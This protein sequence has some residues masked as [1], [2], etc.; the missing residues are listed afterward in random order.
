MTNSLNAIFA[1]MNDYQTN[2]IN[3][4]IGFSSAIADSVSN[5]LHC[6]RRRSISCLSICCASKSNVIQ[7]DGSVQTGQSV[8]INIHRNMRRKVIREWQPST[9]T[10]SEVGTTPSAIMS[11]CTFRTLQLLATSDFGGFLESVN[12]SHSVKYDEV[13]KLMSGQ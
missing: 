5:T 6:L 1:A 9:R 8:I 11:S 7:P 10:C 13:I 4:W 2:Y 3:N 12:D